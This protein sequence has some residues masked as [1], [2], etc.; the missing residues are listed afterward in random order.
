MDTNYLFNVSRSLVDSTQGKWHRYLYHRIDWSLPL[1]CIK[2]ARGIGKTTIMLQRAKE[3]NNSGGKAIYVSLDNIRFTG[4]SLLELVDYHY[5]HGGTHIFI[6]EVHRYMN[7]NWAQEIK[8]IYD[9]YPGYHVAFTGSSLLKIYQ[10]VADLSRRCITYYLQGLSFREYLDMIG[11]CHIAP[12]NLEDALLRHDESAS[13]IL[14]QVKPL[15]HFGTYL[16]HGY[17]PFFN[18]LKNS[19]REALRQ[20]INAIIETDIPATINIERGTI[21]KLRQLLG[22]IAGMT[23]YTP[24]ITRLAELLNSTRQ[25]VTNLLAA[26]DQAALT[27]SL[28][29]GRNVM[30]QLAKPVKVYLENTNLLYAL[31]DDI[32]VGNLR[33]TFFANQLRVGHKLTFSGNG[34]FLIDGRYTIEVGGKDKSFKQIKDIPDSFL[35][36]DDVETTL[37]N[38]VPLWLF[39]FLY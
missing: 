31:T 5:Q 34:D 33:E 26:L 16:Q 10:S 25:H 14:R 29:N 30:Q 4:N 8:N 1:V 24:N 9:S 17:Y 19:Y 35:A 37:G 28:F 2:G 7:D 39:G 20:I 6:D 11:A 32:S 22:I 13:G 15:E 27:G 36:I 18:Q 3:V 21:F 12:I 38:K 23:P